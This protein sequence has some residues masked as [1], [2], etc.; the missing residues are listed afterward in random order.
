MFQS[1]RGFINILAQGNETLRLLFQCYVISVVKCFVCNNSKE[2][3][4]CINYE[5][6]KGSNKDTLTLQSRPFYD[7]TNNTTRTT[8][9]NKSIGKSWT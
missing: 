1:Q 9:T 5:F 6:N 2:L 4:T 7:L 3:I 8:A